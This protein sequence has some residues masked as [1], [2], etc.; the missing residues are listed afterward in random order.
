MR[1]GST[2]KDVMHREH[3]LVSRVRLPRRL[4]IVTEGWPFVLGSG[5]LAGVLAALALAVSPWF[6][7]GAGLSLVATGFCAFFFRDP[8]RAITDDPRA[9]VSPADGR[10]TLVERGGERVRI[11]IFLS[12]FDVHVNRA[13]ATA[14]VSGVDYRPGLFKAAFR[15]DV[16]EVNERNYVRLDSDHGPIEVI[17][18]AGLIARRI[19]CR[20]EP[21]ET[22]LRGERFGMIRFGSC[23]EILLPPEAEPVVSAG[24]RVQGAATIIARWPDRLSR[25][26]SA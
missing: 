18:I 20:V 17:Q 2:G 15:S 1:V 16:H 7:V 22:L 4:G 24:D 25:R 6:W 19:V 3:T 13:P 23:T 8:E 12:V 14:L 10:V 5:S 9:I 26:T 21:G 11:S